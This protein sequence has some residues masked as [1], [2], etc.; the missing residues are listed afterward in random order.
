VGTLLIEGGGVVAGRW[1]AAGLVDRL[2]LVIAP[3]WLGEEGVAAF[4]GL[5]A[6]AIADALRW[7]TV[8]RRALGD[9][10]LI[11]LDRP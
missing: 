4:P 3:L 1:L 7:R 10:T 5:P 9:D 8:E 11:V 6:P 2:Y